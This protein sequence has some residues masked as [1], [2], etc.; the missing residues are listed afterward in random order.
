MSK[1][2]EAVKSIDELKGW[3]CRLK[4]GEYNGEDIMSIWIFLEV[5]LVQAEYELKQML[6]KAI[7]GNKLDRADVMLEE[8]S[9]CPKC[10]EHYIISFMGFRPVEGCTCFINPPC[11]AC[12]NNPLVC[13]TC[14][15]DPEVD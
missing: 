10:K 15:Y 8:G 5:V 11:S 6:N 14:G 1:V 9:Q 3:I 13:K 4:S 7:D 2:E 12:V